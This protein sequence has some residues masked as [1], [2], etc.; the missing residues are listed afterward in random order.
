MHGLKDQYKN[1]QM[2]N[3][4]LMATTDMTGV[5]LEAMG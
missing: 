5:R 1:F 4:T 3:S 2:A